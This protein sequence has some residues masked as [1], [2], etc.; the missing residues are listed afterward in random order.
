MASGY[1]GQPLDAIIVG[2]GPAALNAAL[3]LGRCRR[4]VLVCDRGDHRNAPSQALHGFLSR[5]GV[6]PS[7]LLR[8]GREQLTQY[9]TVEVRQVEVTDARGVDNQFEVTL[10]DGTRLHC[11]KLLLAT[12]MVDELPPLDGIEELLGRSVFHC[13]YC[14]GWEVR[15]Q[16]LA[17][18]GDAQQGPKLALELTAWSRDLVLCTN[19]HAGID[20]G[21]LERLAR[22]G[23]AVREEPIAR[24]EGK[25]GV[26]ERIVFS[27]GEPLPRRAM[28]FITEERQR[29]DLT[30]KLGCEFDNKRAVRTGSYET[31]NIPGLYVAGDASRTVQ[32]AI[33]AA[34]EGAEAAFAINTA[35]LHEDTR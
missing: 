15:D 33:V 21:E 5:D 22:N 7:E 23:I 18:Y 1:D 34:A 35:L 16:P 6:H 31:T 8:I 29:S 2:A 25:D 19:G 28:F 3:I 10:Q 9:E 17:I 26:L 13:P 24:L 20:T 27:T 12:G 4:R 11:R 32:M 14:D 30:A